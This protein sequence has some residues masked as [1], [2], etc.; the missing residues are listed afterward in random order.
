LTFSIFFRIP[1]ASGRFPTTFL[2]TLFSPVFPGLFPDFF[3]GP[4]ACEHVPHHP[5]KLV[6][7]S[8][9]MPMS[10]LYDEVFSDVNLGHG[11]SLSS[12]RVFCLPPEFLC[13][14]SFFAVSF[15]LWLYAIAVLRGGGAFFLPP[16]RQWLKNTVGRPPPFLHRPRIPCVTRILKAQVWNCCC[17]HRVPPCF[18]VPS[19][20]I[21]TPA[22]V[23]VFLSQVFFFSRFC[24]F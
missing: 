14:S 18:C 7:V 3:R 15:S 16:P 4:I 2:S 21:S 17:L 12:L 19:F 22:S 10:S 24:I 20:R 5:L 13:G 1:R 9:R 8:P 6:P 11:S 23:A